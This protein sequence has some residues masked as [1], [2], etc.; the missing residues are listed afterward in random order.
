MR[1]APPIPRRMAPI[2]RVHLIL[3]IRIGFEEEG[4]WKDKFE[5]KPE[6]KKRLAGIVDA[7]KSNL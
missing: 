7:V 6:S 3:F 4:R 5:K 2:I 1:R